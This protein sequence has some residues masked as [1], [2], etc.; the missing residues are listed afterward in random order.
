MPDTVLELRSLVRGYAEPVLTGVDLAVPRGTVMGLL[1]R[2]GAGKSTLLKCGLGILVPESGS[3][4]VF[5]E[6]A[7]ALDEAA[8]ERI[9]YV[10]QALSVFTWMRVRE[11]IA[12]I[13]GFYSRWNQPLIDRLIGEWGV[14]Q[15]AKVGTLS[16]GQAQQL[17]IF[18]ALGHEPELLVLDEPAS[19]LDPVARREFLK[20]VLGIALAGDRTVLFSTHITSDLERVADSVAVLQ[21]G[22]ITYAGSLDALKDQGEKSLEDIFLELHHVG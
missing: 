19:T 22:R 16:P 2:N 21:D 14:P 11:L 6:P 18:L 20:A 3:A 8:K 9:G 5:G 10:P 17:N 15:D 1:G 4:T 12:F 13:G 7:V